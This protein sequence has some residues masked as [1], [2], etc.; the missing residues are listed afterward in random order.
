MGYCNDIIDFCYIIFGNDIVGY[1]DDKIRYFNDKID[2]CN[3]VLRSIV[4][5]KVDCNLIIG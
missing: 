1:G 5:I 4:V 2:I 3:V